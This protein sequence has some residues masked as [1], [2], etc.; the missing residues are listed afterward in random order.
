MAIDNAP[1]ANDTASLAVQ[2]T[3]RG[4]RLRLR[5]RPL[6]GAG[7]GL[8]AALGLVLYLYPFALPYMTSLGDCSGECLESARSNA[9]LL[10]SA[11]L[12]PFFLAGVLLALGGRSRQARR[13]GAWVILA[14]G[15]LAFFPVVYWLSS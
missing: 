5:W 1:T 12:V 9:R 8:L 7:I 3:G 11:V 15:Y 2:P 6:V 10:G 14:G 4:D 13:K